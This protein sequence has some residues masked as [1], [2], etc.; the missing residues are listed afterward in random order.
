M[1][2]YQIK[3]SGKSYLNNTSIQYYI[4]AYFLK[5][6]HNPWGWIN[7]FLFLLF[8]FI[9]KTS[10]TGER[11]KTCLL[12]KSIQLFGKFLF[13]FY[14]FNV[15]ELCSYLE[16]FQG[17]KTASWSFPF[18]AIKAWTCKK[19]LCMGTISKGPKTRWPPYREHP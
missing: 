3:C 6:P 18:F 14:N 13:I 16:L 1:A 19:D 10:L 4:T 11:F 8:F 7:C 9:R 5:F 17:E 15:K 12:F 2:F